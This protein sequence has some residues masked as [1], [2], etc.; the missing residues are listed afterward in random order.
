M[1]GNVVILNLSQKIK[2]EA[3]YYQNQI[4]I[5]LNGFQKNCNEKKPST[6]TLSTKIKKT[7]VVM[8]KPVYLGFFQ[9][10]LE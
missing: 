2:N 9:F 6:A 1:L 10:R 8:N 4:I 5:E 7:K 3:I